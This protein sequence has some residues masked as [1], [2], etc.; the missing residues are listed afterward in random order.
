MEGKSRVLPL[1]VE[2]GESQ[3]P[4][5]GWFENRVVPVPYKRSRPEFKVDR[6]TL[7]TQPLE[8]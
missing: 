3:S 5:A 4:E 1:G 6:S 7:P 8:N 2:T